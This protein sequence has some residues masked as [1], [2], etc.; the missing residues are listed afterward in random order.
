MAKRVLITRIIPSLAHEMLTKAGFDVT[1]WEGSGPM[2]QAQLIERARQVD[3]LLTLGADKLDKTFF[4]ACS[5]LDVIAQYS[6]GYDNIDVNEATSKGIPV[7]N[8]PYVLNNATADVAFGLMIAVSRKMLYQHKTI[9]QGGWKQF[10]PLKNL[11]I[12]LTG[13]TLGVFGMGRIGMVMAQR[14]RGAYDMNIIYHNR[15]RNMEAEKTLAC[16]YVSFDELLK[17]SDVLSVHSV[18]SS[19]TRGIFN[20]SV[21]S[22]MKPSAIFI[23]TSRGSV[24]NEVDLIEALNTGAIWGAGLD[25]TNPE[26]MKPDNPLL[27]MPNAAVLPHIGSGTV[28][29]R[30]GMAR[31]AAE[32]IIEF[33]KSGTMPYCINPGVLKNKSN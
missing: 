20:K 26:P 19:E 16:T 3:A 1:V 10:E 31:V 24:H 21:F 30:N 13:K 29:A 25:V 23:N 17:Q 27:K 22:K 32:N 14:C 12:E 2:A 28:E 33:Y 8:T 6:V 5:H 4:D 11:G 9:E 15:T 7:G 18:L